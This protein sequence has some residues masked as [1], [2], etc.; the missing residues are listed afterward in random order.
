MRMPG[1]RQPAEVLQTARACVSGD[2]RRRSLRGMVAM[3]R[4]ILAVI[5]VAST[6]P[7]GAQDGLAELA[8]TIDSLRR[9]VTDLQA[10]IYKTELPED[11]GTVGVPFDG[12]KLH[13]AMQQI[14]ES[15]RQLAGRVDGLQF[16]QRQLREQL[17]ALEADFAARTATGALSS[18]THDGAQPPE[19]QT[20]AVAEEGL[21]PPGT[22]A[23]KY[24]HAFSLL[25]KADY[26]AAEQAFSAFIAEYPDSELVG[27]AWHWIGSMHSVR[28][29][30]REA[31]VAFLKS[32]QEAPEG[33]KS[34]GSLLKLGTSLVQLGKQGEACA[35][36]REFMERFPDA[37]EA[38][39]AQAREEATATGCT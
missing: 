8:Q 39:L 30:H 17:A 7:A 15:L 1:P 13:A 37:G 16:S 6:G 26:D 35:T 38:L 27:N 18:Q 34:A 10:F 32:Y 22:E 20:V 31:A 14:E 5:V 25:R 21:L 24:D 4:L 36:F 23:E 33:S 11:G 3:K 12:S 2:G 9:D 28:D 19:L 29:Q